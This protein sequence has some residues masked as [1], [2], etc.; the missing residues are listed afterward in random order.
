M[1]QEDSW[2]KK[3]QN[4]RTGLQPVKPRACNQLTRYTDRL[5]TCSTNTFLCLHLN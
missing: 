1:E 2:I 5:Q 4:C 3:F